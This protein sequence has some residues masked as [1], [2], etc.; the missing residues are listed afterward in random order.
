MSK[1]LHVFAQSGP[2]DSAWIVGG[3][4]S[5][6]ALRDAIT[7]LLDKPDTFIAEPFFASD[8]EGYNCVVFHHNLGEDSALPY[9]DG[10]ELEVTNEDAVWPWELA[11]KIP[12][13]EG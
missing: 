7:Y 5:L 6:A 2:H 13:Y 12:P 9:I 4:K 1:N 10:K 3:R 11:M 8:G